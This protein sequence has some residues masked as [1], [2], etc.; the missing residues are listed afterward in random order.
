MKE[1]LIDVNGT[2]GLVGMKET[3]L[4]ELS[5]GLENPPGQDKV[6]LLKNSFNGLKQSAYFIG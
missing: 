4:A 3:V 6:L 5:Q 1:I 2:F